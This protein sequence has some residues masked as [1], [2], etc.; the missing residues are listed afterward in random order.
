MKIFYLSVLISLSTLCSF[1]QVTS[2]NIDNSNLNLPLMHQLDSIY[3]LDQSTRNT[4]LAAKQRKEP[5]RIIDSL[6]KEMHKTDK[7]NLLKVNAI[8]KRFGWLGPQKV[9]INGAQALF[10][11]IQHA[12]LKTQEYYLPI[13][14][15]AEKRGEILSSN[16]AILE[17][18]ICMRTGKKQIYGSQG[19]TDAQT[20]KKYI[21]PIRDIDNLDRRRNKMGMPPMQDYVKGWN[22]EEYRKDLP[23]IERIVKTQNIK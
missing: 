17:D 16:L 2:F 3:K 5:D 21:Y 8:I 18:R 1:G 15:N 14:R 11:V 22:L 6:L 7:E 13:I 19:F 20:E 23:N 4:Y 10:L 12:D 9:G